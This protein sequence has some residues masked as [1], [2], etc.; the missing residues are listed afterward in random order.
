MFAPGQGSL[1]V[2]PARRAW[3]ARRP[4]L[5]A[6][7]SA[8]CMAVAITVSTVVMVSHE[9][10]R[11][12]D[13]RDQAVKSYVEWFMTQFT[14]LDPFHANAYVTRVLAQATGDFAKHFTDKANEIILEVARAEPTTGTVLD[15]GVERWND[16]GSAR[17]LV[18]TEV[19]SKSP[20]EK[21]VVEN[22]NRWTTTAKQ[23][24]NQWKISDLQKV[25]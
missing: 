16:D 14:T 23:E 20:D 9:S 13:R 4:S 25:T 11:Q 5:I 3:R 8:V 15:V 2:P 19:T 24:G 22:T 12:A 10:H 1:L 7:A 21:Q 17:V 18:V 6:V